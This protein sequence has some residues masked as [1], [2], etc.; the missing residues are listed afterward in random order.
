MRAQAVGSWSSPNRMMDICLWAITE[1]QNL[2]PALMWTKKWR[3]IMGKM[4]GQMGLWGS[5]PEAE[6]LGLL[7]LLLA[8]APRLLSSVS[9]CFLQSWTRPFIFEAESTALD[10]IDNLKPKHQRILY[11]SCNSMYQKGKL[12]YFWKRNK[13]SKNSFSGY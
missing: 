11:P 3:C 13:N 5:E 7:M 2:D 4:L 12:C 1:V 9:A 6:M 10:I 8:Q